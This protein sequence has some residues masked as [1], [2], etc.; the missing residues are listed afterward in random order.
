MFPYDL[1]NMINFLPLNTEW[2]VYIHTGLQRHGWSF[3]SQYKIMSCMSIRQAHT[4]I[5]TLHAQ[6]NNND[7]YMYIN[8]VHLKNAFI[9]I[10]NITNNL[11]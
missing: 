3:S 5:N 2:K 9:Q 1:T 7:I 8:I 11:S 10:R 6:L 4:D